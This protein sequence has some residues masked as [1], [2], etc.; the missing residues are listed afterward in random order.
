MGEGFLEKE[1]AIGNLDAVVADGF[2]RATF[3]GFLAKVF[4]IR[5]LGLFENVAMA[6]VIISREVGRRG[7]PAEVTVN[8]LIVDVVLTFDVF[9]IF[10]S[11]VGH[12]FVFFRAAKIEAELGIAMNFCPRPP[13]YDNAGGADSSEGFF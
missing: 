13:R 6:T 3:H 2:H 8:A 5:T 9:G 4:F 7:L 1:L 10:I 12:L 11:E